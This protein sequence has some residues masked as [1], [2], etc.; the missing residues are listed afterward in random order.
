MPKTFLI[1]GATRG[2]GLEFTTR[3][4]SQGNIVIAT[5]RSPTSSLLAPKSSTQPPS[6]ASNLWALTGSPNGH[7]LTILECDVSDESS[8]KHFTDEVRKL[9]RRGGVL[10]R[11]VLDVVVLNAGVLEYPGRISEI[12]F[13][14]FSHHLH[15]NTIGP[16]LTASHLLILSTPP[17]L[18]TPAPSPSSL[19]NLSPSSSNYA[20][21]H[22]LSPLSSTYHHNP[23]PIH[24]KTLV[25]ISSDSGSTT[26]FRSF[27]DGFGAYAASKAALNQGLRHLAA[28]IHRK[29]T[30][31]QFQAQISPLQDQSSKTIFLAL[32][33]GEVSTDMA[34]NV[35]PDWDVEGIISPEESIRCMLKVIAEKGFGGI[36]EGGVWSAKSEGRKREDGEAT[37]WTWEG[38]QYPW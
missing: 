27:E 14:A 28:E 33:P 16:L 3:L 37:F 15:T 19:S 12:T 2:I 6:N 25:F 5:A 17:S 13:S 34:A 35:S 18:P 30:K 36:D 23:N 32:H 1:V 38:E 11:G 8:I 22:P 26:N 7:N 20:L 31:S 4:L 21:P 9:G 29:N 10:E 24:I